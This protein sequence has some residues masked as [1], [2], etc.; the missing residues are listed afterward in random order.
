MKQNHKN[1]PLWIPLLVLV[2]CGCSAECP[3]SQNYK[4]SVHLIIQ[5]NSDL[6]PHVT[7]NLI[8]EVS[9]KVRSNYLLGIE[10]VRNNEIYVL[11]AAFSNRQSVREAIPEL[12][13]NPETSSLDPVSSDESA[14]PKMLQ[15]CIDKAHKA[16]IE[17][18]ISYCIIVT[19][20]TRD[21]KIISQLNSMSKS[22]VDRRLH[23]STRLYLIGV[24]P[25]NRLQLTSGFSPLEQQVSIASHL[26]S[27]WLPFIGEA[28]KP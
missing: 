2:A 17:S 8:H 21:N 28:L 12:D 5:N 10:Q 19:P 16:K 1:Q 9:R 25:E 13:G 11:L 27:Q 4:K 15:R 22:L 24:I 20:G 14:L 18:R 26:D 7:E 6:D 23:K 3:S